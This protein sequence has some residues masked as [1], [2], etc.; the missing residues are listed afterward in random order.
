MIR[1]FTVL[2]TANAFGLLASF[3]LGWVSKLSGGYQESAN[4]HFMYH[5]YCGLFTA[6]CTLLVHCLILTYGLGTGRWVREVSLVY[7]LPDAPLYKTT[8]DLKRTTTPLALGA[9]L[10]TIAAA[11]MGAGVQLQGW[12]WLT[13]L[14]GACLAIGL[15]GWAYIVEFRGLR[16]IE[17]ILIAVYAEV[18]RVRAERGLPSN[19][20][21]LRMEAESK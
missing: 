8:R 7:G 5:F 18:D 16:K 15:N 3:T 20:E 19:E 9:M 14:T 11:A 21:A 10:G 13:H 4:A 12:T 2:A 17:A 1:I 6:I